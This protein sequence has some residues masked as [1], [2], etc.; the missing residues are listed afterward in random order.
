VGGQGEGG[1]D[2]RMLMTLVIGDE[3]GEEEAIGC[4][5]FQRRRG[6]GKAAPQH[7]RRTPQRRVMRWPR[8][9]KVATGVY[10]SKMT[11]GNWIGGP[12]ARLG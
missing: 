6:G 8:R 7:R 3:N 2:G 4:D 1:S 9:P 5:H 12:N 10:R 11:K